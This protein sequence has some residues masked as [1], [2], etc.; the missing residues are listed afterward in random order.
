MTYREMTIGLIDFILQ[1]KKAGLSQEKTFDIFW[2]FN[3]ED[4]EKYTSK[5]VT[6]KVFYK[7]WNDKDIA[8]LFLSGLS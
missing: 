2:R 6:Q 4:Y 5:K 1:N 7:M 8:K 3:S